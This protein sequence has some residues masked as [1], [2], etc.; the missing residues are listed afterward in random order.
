M[1]VFA[2]AAHFLHGLAV[3]AYLH[4]PGFLKNIGASQVEIGVMASTLA[5]TAIACRPFLGRAMD[6][7]GRRPVIIASGVLHVLV[8]LSYL[9]VH[10]IGPWV[11]FIRA[12]HG[13]ATAMIF[14]ALFTYA[15]D[16]VPE[17]RRT[18]GIALFGVSGLLP[19]AIGSL[20]G[21]AVLAFVDYRELFYITV[22][23]AACGL[24][25]SF[26]LE[27][28]RRAEH[29]DPSRGFFSAAFQKNL[30]PLWFIG[31]AF[32]TSLS[33]VFIF[34]KIFVLDTGIGSV[35]LFM[36]AYAF[37]AALLRVFFGWIPD[38]FGPKRALVPAIGALVIGLVQLAFANSTT[39]IIVSGVLCGLGHG[40]AFPI[41]AGLVVNRSG[42]GDRG[43]AL[44]LFTAVFDAGFL[45]GGPLFGALI[46]SA[47]YQTTYLVAAAIA[48]GGIAVFTVWDHVIDA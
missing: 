30:M 4:L 10:S 24:L 40:F 21:D 48:V 27:E 36:G 1:F 2:S 28:P 44:S 16:I 25:L 17:K 5:I 8:C 29:V 18:E 47:S 12:V 19:I 23:F 32:A 11:Y 31:T 38:R 6:V 14:S 22:G 26:P 9:T 35:G 20:I 34:L 15:A 37:S 41:I 39:D 3:H 43:S 33:A 45:V 46:E 42:S 7:R 13:V